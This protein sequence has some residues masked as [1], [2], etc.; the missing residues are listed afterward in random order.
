[1]K[2]MAFVFG[3]LCDA[4]CAKVFRRRTAAALLIVGVTALIYANGLHTPFVFDDF[5]SIVG[6]PRLENPVHFLK[7]ASLGQSRILVDFTFALNK[8]LAG[9]DV[10]GYHLVNIAIHALNAWLVYALTLTLWKALKEKRGL[11]F[12][13]NLSPDEWALMTSLLFA[14][15]PVQTQ[16]VTYIVQRYASMAA[17][18][19]LLSVLCFVKG[20]LIWPSSQQGAHGQGNR[21]GRAFLLPGL[22]FLLCFVGAAAAFLSKQ[23]SASLPLMLAYMEFVLF[24]RSW[25]G[26]LRKAWVALPLVIL[27]GLFLVAHLGGTLKWG[28]FGR[29]LEDA[30]RATRETSAVDRWAYAVTQLRAIC[31]YLGLLLFPVRQ[32]LDYGYP[33]VSSLFAGWTPLA[34]VLLLAMAATAIVGLRRQPWVSL[35][36]GW[37]FIAL[38]VE[39][40]IF[41]IRDALFEHRIYLPSV[42]FFWAITWLLSW[43]AQRSRT[44]WVLITVILI[45]ALGTATHLR[46]RIWQ[47]PA[48]LWR[49]AVERNPS[50]PRAYNN[51]GKA[52]MDR[53]D[54]A[55][56]Q[57]A[58]ETALR[59]DPKNFEA[60]LNRGLSLARQG[61]IGE[62]LPAFQQSLALRP[63]NPTALY[64]IALAYHK[65]RLYDSAQTYY[66][67]ALQ[68]DPSMEKAALNLANLFVEQKLFDQALEILG[69]YAASHPDAADV[70]HNLAVLHLQNGRADEAQKVVDEAL[71]RRPR[72]APL[73]VLKAELSLRL[74]RIEAARTAL[75]QALRLSPKNAQALALK[76]QLPSG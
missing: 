64:N 48:A 70:L 1:M 44:A 55:Q 30:D 2:T 26:W 9:D 7:H 60:H 4:F 57:K 56:A 50:H 40:S 29:L 18:F 41:P 52:L 33:F 28:D 32:C 58:F 49:E 69:S 42:G 25:R 36:V 74:G 45:V 35:A 54:D 24:D 53:G 19:Y 38:S 43:I 66:R 15:H 46:N 23:N 6:N 72:S 65:M 62:A 76:K 59:L 16:A 10:V 37:F 47:N 39:S 3:T 75:D 13:A 20:R 31:I 8:A 12:P 34:A 17:T 5:N 73:W 27:F 51:Y 21:R 14:C 22:Y 67:R 11:D 71:S 68:A 61:L 63:E